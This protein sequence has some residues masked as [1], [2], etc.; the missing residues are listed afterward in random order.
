MPVDIVTDVQVQQVFIDSRP[1]MNDIIDQPVYVHQKGYSHE[2]RG[3]PLEGTAAAYFLKKIHELSL[4]GL[5]GDGVRMKAVGAA[6]GRLVKAVG[7]LWVQ[8]VEL[9]I[10]ISAEPEDKTAVG[11]FVGEKYRIVGG[12]RGDEETVP[13]L[14]MVQLVLDMVVH[15]ALQKEVQLI[16]IV[17]VGGDTGERDI[18]VIKKL[19]IN[20]LHVL[21]GI[22]ICR[23]PLFHTLPPGMKN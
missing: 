7:E 11:F 21:A 6:G 1:L 14:Q 22:K 20:G 13:V 18:A 23:Q 19:K 4:Q 5:G 17:M 8:G 16:I 3:L 2:L 12:L 9:V 15:I 10:V